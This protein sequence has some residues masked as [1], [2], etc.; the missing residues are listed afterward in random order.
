MLRRADRH[1]QPC[2]AQVVFRRACG[3]RNAA[4]IFLF[5]AHQPQRCWCAPL[6]P[7]SISWVGQYACS[8]ADACAFRA[9][10]ALERRHH[11]HRVSRGFIISPPAP[12][13]ARPGSTRACRTSTRHKHCTF[14]VPVQS[15]QLHSVFL[16]PLF[17]GIMRP[18][19]GQQQQPAA[20]STPSASA[21]PKPEATWITDPEFGFVRIKVRVSARRANHRWVWCLL[22]LAGSSSQQKAQATKHTL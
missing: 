3:A 7:S 14:S 9:A 21:A 18:G 13:N 5:S 16:R 11:R 22:L 6:R 17:A 15:S 1:Q 12:L 19:G 8:D 10:C 20:T 2:R 4:A